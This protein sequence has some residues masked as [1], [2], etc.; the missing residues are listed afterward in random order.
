MTMN[1]EPN[2]TEIPV[3]NW[4]EYASCRYHYQELFFPDK[5][6]KEFVKAAK[7][8]CSTCIVRNECL[9]DAIDFEDGLPLDKR[10]GVWGNKTPKERFEL[11][12]P[13]L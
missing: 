1:V 9:E 3:N 12:N 7:Y 8:I 5:Y 6:T 11:S 10:F 4:D 13:E 2:T